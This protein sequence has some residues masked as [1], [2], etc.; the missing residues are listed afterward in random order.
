[1]TGGNHEITRMIADVR[2]RCSVSS[3]AQ[4][5]GVKLKATWEGWSARCP[6]HEDGTPSFTIFDNDRKF[7]CFGCGCE[8]RGDVIDFVRRLHNVGL[9]EAIAILNGEAASGRVSQPKPNAKPKADT[10]AAALR[11]IDG[12]RPIEGTP[13]EAYLRHRAITMPLPSCL[14]FAMLA[15]PK[16]SGVLEVNGPGPMP[17]LVAII[18]GKDGKPTGIQRIYL[19]SDGR[20]AAS[21]DGK[22]KFSLGFVAGGAVRL[23]TFCGDDVVT[24]GSVEDGLS[25]IQMGAP[26]VWAAPGES[27]LHRMWLPDEAR[28]VVIGG[29]A[30]AE[31]R[32]AADRAAAAFTV[33]GRGVWIIYPTAPCKDFNEELQE[34]AA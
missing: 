11:I 28:S 26:A 29:D 18:S 22:V 32:R 8:A 30:D 6:F 14:R 31:G 3:I 20:K 27:M 33:A 5:A 4:A 2:N 10:Q 17:A 12:S 23:S 9:R 19:T 21:R 13:A 25:L 15:P 34:S 24:S 1:M 16:N 7:Q